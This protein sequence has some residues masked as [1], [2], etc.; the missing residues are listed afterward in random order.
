MNDPRG[1]R[2]DPL[3]G[4]RI[5]VTRAADDSG[6]LRHAL[7]PLG[8]VVVEIPS[9]QRVSPEDWSSAD[10]ALRA[11]STYH[12]VLFTSRHTVRA[13]FTRMSEIGLLATVP[14]GVLAGAVGAATTNALLDRGVRV[15][16]TASHGTGESLA[17]ELMN[18][19]IDG[20]RVLIPGSDL[21]RPELGEMLT[22][23]GADVQQIVVYRTIKPVDPSAS[24]D[25]LRRGEVDVVVFASPSA[26]RNLVDMLEGRV[27][28]LRGV[29]CV[30]IGPTTA[31][32]VE[33]MGLPVSAVSDDRTDD[34][35]VGA[36]L[37]L[38]DRRMR[39]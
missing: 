14:D 18:R 29:Q 12:W 20:R 13:V 8:A 38:T 9:I 25:A 26:V 24:M 36:I 33:A 2:P 6:G 19:G 34:G 30:C 32:A 3:S 22:Q 7:E 5:A 4:V 11:L 35:L 15:D 37:R 23:A 1:S 17:R 27:E 10:S 16:C 31:G 21:A 28:R 39:T